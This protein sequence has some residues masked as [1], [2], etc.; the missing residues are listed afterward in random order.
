MKKQKENNMRIILEDNKTKDILE[1]LKYLYDIFHSDHFCTN[2]DYQQIIY[3][4]IT[5]TLKDLSN[6]EDQYEFMKKY[7]FE[8]NH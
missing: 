5:F 8:D 2:K 6:S 3:D 4:Q 1:N 7:V